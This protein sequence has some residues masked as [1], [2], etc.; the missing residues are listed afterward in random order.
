M[1]YGR[2]H[3][4]ERKE[5]G[6]GT[7]VK[8]KTEMIT[9]HLSSFLWMRMM[10]ISHVS[11]L[12]SSLAKLTCFP[13]MSDVFASVSLPESLIDFICMPREE[14]NFPW[15]E[16][17]LCMCV[18]LCFWSFAQPQSFQ[19]VPPSCPMSHSQFLL[20]ISLLWQCAIYGNPLIQVWAQ[21]WSLV[22]R[23]PS[24]HA[25]QTK[26]WQGSRVERSKSNL[27]HSPPPP[28]PTSVR[29]SL[30]SG[31]ASQSFLRLAPCVILLRP[32]W[33]TFDL[34]LALASCG[35]CP[36]AARTIS[37]LSACRL[38]PSPSVQPSSRCPQHSF[39]QTGQH[40]T[41]ASIAPIAI[42]CQTQQVSRIVSSGSPRCLCSFRWL[43]KHFCLLLD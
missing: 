20:F 25:T 12:L 34:C 19:A 3:T 17:N 10:Q 7:C 35:C 43:P 18:W 31:A 1:A 28:S 27:H 40:D 32:S 15:Y 13:I 42:H 36:P 38:S 33:F 23:L 14:R 22:A 16:A 30:Q 5:E 24:Q 21:H 8:M 41:R 2:R 6:C 11:V 39:A 9:T 37:T 29:A 26:K 4:F